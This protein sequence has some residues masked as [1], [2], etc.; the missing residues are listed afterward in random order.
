MIARRGSIAF[1]ALAVGLGLAACTSEVDRYCA[2]P[3][4]ACGY[5][6]G[7]NEINRLRDTARVELGPKYDLRQFDDAVVMGGNVPM[8]VLAKNVGEYIAKTKAT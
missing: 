7:H 6:V 2:S 5:K 1:A 3:G 4:Q 8:D